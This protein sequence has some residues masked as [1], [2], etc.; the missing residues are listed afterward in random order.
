L[1]DAN[2]SQK[3]RLAHGLLVLGDVPVVVCLIHDRH[4]ENES[5]TP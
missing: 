2:E 5:D 4:D 3:S 1:L